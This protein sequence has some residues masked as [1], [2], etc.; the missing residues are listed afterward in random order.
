MKLGTSF[1]YFSGNHLHSAADDVN[2]GSVCQEGR[3]L[4]KKLYELKGYE[5]KRLMK[6]FHTKG[7]KKTTTLRD[8]SKHLKR[9]RTFLQQDNASAR[10]ACNIDCSMSSA[11]IFTLNG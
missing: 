2:N 4:I 7:W 8:F 6:E 10:R 1:V 3:I 9:K 11:D 5:T